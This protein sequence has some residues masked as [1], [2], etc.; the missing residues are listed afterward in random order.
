MNLVNEIG[1]LRNRLSDSQGRNGK[2]VEPSRSM[3]DWLLTL[4]EQ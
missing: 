2:P 4:L 1:T 3:P